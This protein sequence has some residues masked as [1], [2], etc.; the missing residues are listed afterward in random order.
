MRRCLAGI[1]HFPPFFLFATT[2]ITMR[3]ALTLKPGLLAAA[4]LLGA[5]NDRVKDT[6]PQRWVSQRQAAFKQLTKALEPMGLVARERQ[7]YNKA[8]FQSQALEL[9]E[10]S[11]KPWAYFT[12]DSNYPP[13][14]AKP[15][16]WQD[17][18]GFKQ[19]QDSY[20]ARVAQLA[21]VAGS[22]DV[23]AIRSAVDAVEKSCKA[24]HDQSRNER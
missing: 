20:Q 5:C 14:R 10:L 7:D 22:A 21:K 9:Q 3:I 19:A 6:H 15:S 12:P 11:G 1:G 17:A 23:P 13:T 18:A 24:C 4:L 8:E 2:H 16:V